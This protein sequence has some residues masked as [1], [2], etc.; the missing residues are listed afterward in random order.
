MVARSVQYLNW[1]YCDR[2]DRSYK[3]Y[4]AYKND[5]QLG[6]CVCGHTERDRIKIGLIMDIFV[7]PEDQ[8]TLNALTCHILNEMEREGEALASCLLQPKSPFLK[9]LKNNGFVFPL[10][11]FPPFIL[12]LNSENVKLT[13]INKINDWHITFGDADFV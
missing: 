12:K 5:K 9:V 2:P 3:I 13:E 11:R 4:L 1:R 8:L 7:A 6:Y 10:T